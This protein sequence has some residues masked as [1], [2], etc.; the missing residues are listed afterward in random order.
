MSASVTCPSGV[1]PSNVAAFTVRLR[2]V[3]GPRRAG[4]NTSGDTTEG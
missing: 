4:A 1:R 3:T 2:S